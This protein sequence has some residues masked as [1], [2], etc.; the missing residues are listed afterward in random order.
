MTVTYRP[1][2][3]LL[4][5]LGL[6]HLSA[7]GVL[8]QAPQPATSIFGRTHA[9]RTLAL[10]AA[11]VTLLV[12]P[13]ATIHGATVMLGVGGV[14]AGDGSEDRLGV[15]IT[16]AGGLRAPVFL[17]LGI[18]PGSSAM[19]SA[20]VDGADQPCESRDGILAC[21]IATTGTYIYGRSGASPTAGVLDQALTAARDAHPPA[22][23]RSSW[24]YVALAS[25]ALLV[26]G[27]AL[28]PPP[29]MFRSRIDEQ[30]PP[31]TDSDS[32]PTRP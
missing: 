25:A 27:L 11:G 18:E 14:P 24:W 31:S 29:S 10:A 16:A 2:H 15:V 22:P 20:T 5:T 26:A 3:L 28:F 13:D 9:D 17:L 1:V 30:N 23:A 7:P 19:L 12:P 8:A 4:L 6:L 32:G 21:R